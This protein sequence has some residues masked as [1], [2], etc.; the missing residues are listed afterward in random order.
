VRFPQGLAHFCRAGPIAEGKAELIG[1]P[2]RN[3]DGAQDRGRVSNRLQPLHHV[4][5]LR[6]DPDEKYCLRI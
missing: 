3:E 5:K 2:V 6:H 1:I 4:R